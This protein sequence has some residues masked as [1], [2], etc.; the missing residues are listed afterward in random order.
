LLSTPDALNVAGV[1]PTPLAAN[2]AISRANRGSF[3]IRNR[4][5]NEVR[6]A[7]PARLMRHPLD[8]R[9]LNHEVVMLD[10]SH[11]Y[12]TLREE[13]LQAKRYVFERPLVIVALGVGGL[14]T[15]KTEYMGALALLLAGLILFNFWFTVNRLMSAARIIAYIQLALEERKS[16]P[17]VGWESSLRYYRKWLKRD[18]SGTKAIVDQE[19]DGDAVPDAMLHYPPIYQLHIALMAVVG[20]GAAALTVLTPSMVNIVSMVGIVGLIAIFGRDCR[21]YRPSII[22]ALIERNRVIWS[23]VFTYM[24]DE[25]KRPTQRAGSVQQADAVDAASPLEIS[26]HTRFYG[27]LWRRLS[28]ALAARVKPDLLCL[29]NKK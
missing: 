17:W 9:T 27:V 20:V 15:L 12:A 7:N 5:R 24:Q 8:G 21:K 26:G 2:H 6:I 1:H 29:S 4:S 23:Y 3:C 18:P 10:Q 16:E 25:G 11:E 14:T 13:L 22:S 19:M 28:P